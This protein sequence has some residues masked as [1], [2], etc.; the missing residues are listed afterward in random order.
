MESLGELP[1]EMQRKIRNKLLETGT[2]GFTAIALKSLYIDINQ[3]TQ[4]VTLQRLTKE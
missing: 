4:M 3:G 1:C 2:V